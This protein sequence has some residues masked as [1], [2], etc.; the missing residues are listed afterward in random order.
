M[1]V[2]T[3]GA[4]V[5]LLFVPARAA[6]TPT[7]AANPNPTSVDVRVG[8]AWVSQP[9]APGFIGFSFE[10]TAVRDY[11]GSDPRAINPVLV[12]LIRDVAPGQTPVL[13]IGG[14]S[15][16]GTWWPLP[17]VTPSPGINYA[18]TKSWLATTRA[19]AV[20]TRAKLILGVNLKDD[21]SAEAAAE[22]Y[23]YRTGIGAKHIEALEI[24]NEPELYKVFPWY[25]INGE[26]FYARPPI[27]DFTS[28]TQEIAGIA[29]QVRGVTLAGPATGTPQWF[30]AVP[31]LFAVERRLKVV[32]YHR[33]PLLACFSQPGDPRYPSIPNLLNPDSARAL[34]TGA[35]DVIA[36][37]HKHGA[38][39]RIDELNSVACAGQPGVSDTFAS[40]LWMLD[41]LFA[42]ARSG[43]DGVNIHTLPTASYKPFEFRR[44]RGRWLATVEPEYYALLMFEQAA[45]PGSRMLNIIQ[46]ASTDI[47]SR[48]TLAPDGD[49]HVVLINDSLTAGHVVFVKPPAKGH[50]AVLE[51]LS[52]SSAAATDDVTLGGQTF[53]NETGTGELKGKLRTI[54]VKPDHRGRYLIRLPVSTAAMLTFRRA[55]ASPPPGPRTGGSR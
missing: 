44:I 22:A 35:G 31:Q 42:M 17:G 3:G 36:Y 6:T 48:A 37:A 55:A 24:G 20:E 5:P 27:Y 28:Y 34:L 7:P 19:L 21:S 50:T 54:G 12:A 8:K 43:V 29:N 52:A 30:A 45:P 9:V 25:E 49:V 39:V 4:L 2:A 40:G 16:D 47:R 10:F 51:R 15:T 32:T 46:T 38:T 33:Y 23:A 14:N 1:V 41:T 26:P 13:R 11:T 18:L 53:G